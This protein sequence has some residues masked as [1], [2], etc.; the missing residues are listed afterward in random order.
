MILLRGALKMIVIKSFPTRQERQMVW[1]ELGGIDFEGPKT[2][3][4]NIKAFECRCGSVPS[5]L[6]DDQ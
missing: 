6:A 2:K 5:T 4:S 3:W 1:Q